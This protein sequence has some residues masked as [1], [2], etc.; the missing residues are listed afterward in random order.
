[1]QS[2][3][4]RSPVLPQRAVSPTQQILPRREGPSISYSRSS[5]SR[6]A[7]ESKDDHLIPPTKPTL[8]R[9]ESDSEA[10]LKNPYKYKFPIPGQ[11]DNQ[12]RLAEDLKRRFHS[13][14]FLER[15]SN[16]QTK[17]MMSVLN[18][19]NTTLSR[20]MDIDR[21]SAKHQNP[22]DIKSV[23]R[24]LQ[25]NSRESLNKV[26]KY[27]N[28]RRRSKQYSKQPASRRS[29]TSSFLNQFSTLNATNLMNGDKGSESSGSSHTLESL[30]APIISADPQL[31]VSPFPANLPSKKLPDR[32]KLQPRPQLPTFVNVSPN[33]LPIPSQI[34]ISTLDSSLPCTPVAVCNGSQLNSGASKFQFK[35]FPPLPGKLNGPIA[36]KNP[37]NSS[38]GSLGTGKRQRPSLPKTAAAS[39]DNKNLFRDLLEIKG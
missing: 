35:P 39:N 10:F 3:S 20:S 13:T 29:S 38:S 24:K 33:T 5:H 32:H 8:E 19:Q 12:N 2:D 17:E 18:T 37:L 1:M 34:Y 26:Q 36:Q 25:D 21:I 15:D 4:S 16:G 23:I 14:M 6:E 30:A 28:K 9:L 11:S 31:Q 7:S 22:S 27:L